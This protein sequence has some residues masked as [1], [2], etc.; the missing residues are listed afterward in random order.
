MRTNLKLF[1]VK[2]G[3]SQEDI[4]FKIGCG[5]ATYASVETGKRNGTNSFWLALQKAFSIPDSEMW[6]LIKRD[7]E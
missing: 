5:R 3:L 2:N 6:G 7:E 4:A 1:R